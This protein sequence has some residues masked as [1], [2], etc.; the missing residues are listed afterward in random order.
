MRHLRKEALEAVAFV[1]KDETRPVLNG[2]HVDKRGWTIGTDGHR[3]VA[4]PPATKAERENL[5]ESCPERLTG[6]PERELPVTIPAETVKGWLR[7]KAEA[8][9]LR[10]KSSHPEVSSEVESHA[11]STFGKGSLK[12]VIDPTSATSGGVRELEGPYPNIPQIVPEPDG[13]VS[14]S[15]NAKYLAELARLAV[16]TGGNNITH[17]IVLHFSAEK[18]ETRPMVASWGLENGERALAL[19]MPLRSENHEKSREAVRAFRR[20]ESAPTVVAKAA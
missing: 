2:V 1:S 14:I 19:V 18:A 13:G 6:M 4:F 12:G 5:A 16:K 20:G 10:E 8:V 7:G 15:L 17:E 9:F 3:L 11:F